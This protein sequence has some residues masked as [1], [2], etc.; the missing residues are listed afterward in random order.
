[1]GLVYLGLAGPD[2][3]FALRRQQSVRGGRRA[4]RERSVVD[5]LEALRRELNGLER[6]A[7]RS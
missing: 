6:L 3:S 7:E 2:G 5:A 4:V 1:M